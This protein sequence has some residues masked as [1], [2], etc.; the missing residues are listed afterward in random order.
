MRRANPTRKI[1]QLIVLCVFA[2]GTA[3]GQEFNDARTVEVFVGSGET[4]TESGGAVTLPVRLLNRSSGTQSVTYAVELPDGWSIATP[5]VPVTLRA[6]ESESRILLVR[7]PKGASA[8]RYTVHV[9]T[10]G[11]GGRSFHRVRHE[12]HV[13]P[14]C[15]VAL[16]V[17]PDVEFVEAGGL[18][19]IDTKLRNEGNVSLQA[20][21][22]V[23][24]HAGHRIVIPAD[25]LS[26]SPTAS[27]KLSVRVHVD[28]HV[29]RKTRRSVVFTVKPIGCAESVSEISRTV[30][31]D[32]IPVARDFQDVNAWIPASVTLSTGGGSSGI[33]G[34]VD[35][36]ASG[37]VDRDEKRQIDLHVRL[38]EDRTTR[39][40]RRSLVKARYL[41]NKVAVTVGDFRAGYGLLSSPSGVGRGVS[42]DA[43]HNSLRGGVFWSRPH[44]RFPV[45]ARSGVMLGLARGEQASIGAL[46]SRQTGVDRR[47]S[48]T[49][50]ARIAPI[51]DTDLLLEFGDSFR[52]TSGASA[53]AIQLIGSRR[54]FLTYSG[55]YIYAGPRFPGQ[56]ANYDFTQGSVSF[57]PVSGLHVSSGGRIERRTFESVGDGVTSQKTNELYDLGV[58]W[59]IRASQSEVTTAA[60]V[61]YS[62]R[63]LSGLSAEAADQR[64]AGLE[65]RLVRRHFAV[66][67][68]LQRGVYEDRVLQTTDTF[69]RTTLSARAGNSSRKAGVAFDWSSGRMITRPLAGSTVG[70]RVNLESRVTERLRLEMNAYVSRDGF[71]NEGVYGLVDLRAVRT[72]RNGGQFS[73]RAVHSSVGQSSA[74]STDLGISLRWP[75]AVPNLLGARSPRFEVEIV[76]FE[77][78]KPLSGVLVQLGDQH[79]LT[80]SNGRIT[81]RRPDAGVHLLRLDM[82]TVGVDYVPMAEMPLALDF[83]DTVESVE[84]PV[85]R[86][87]S[88]TIEAGM[89]SRRASLVAEGQDSGPAPVVPLRSAVIEIEDAFGR[90]RAV[91][92]VAGKTTFLHVRPGDYTV[93]IVY[94]SLP[95]HYQTPSGI[96]FHVEP[97]GDARIPLTAV[98]TRRQIQ[99]ITVRDDD[100]EEPDEAV[101][102]PPA[103]ASCEPIKTELTLHIVRNGESLSSIAGRYYGEPLMWPLIW[104]ANRSITDDPDLI[105][106]GHELEIET[107]GPSL[108]PV[109]YGRQTE[110]TTTTGDSLPEIS[111]RFTGDSRLWPMI[112]WANRSGIANPE[113]LPANLTLRWPV[114]RLI[115]LATSS[116]DE[117]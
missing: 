56:F 47:E 18:L 54:G 10:S 50:M 79:A 22:S 76:E 45:R 67:A 84:V 65:L 69:T 3:S 20:V 15:S 111:T 77:S 107:P 98:P 110:Y 116:C 55:R 72:L 52:G 117:D 115:P 89:L 73:V 97:G 93:R 26:V 34:H 28:E 42:I 44:F 105:H 46:F 100:S 90:Y 94:A 75:F 12:I 11:K 80:D 24:P 43:R 39:F 6:N 61:A 2:Y 102:P 71:W 108:D 51:R 87:S 5:P 112:W 81:L 82:S 60:T 14:H 8:G 101:L 106:A 38:P 35:V 63:S 99:M 27:R 86:A 114:M 92:N 7:V 85:A 33:G 96:S 29:R 48:V 95:P 103:V 66:G 74:G 49:L 58:G 113:Q 104:L 19:T 40:G 30:S 83:D 25:T 109:D 9:S 13:L 32:V 36:A 31:F 16:D 23:R 59:R 88:V 21:L 57:R 53:A 41:T 17:L 78:G 91:T 68:S 37:Y 62:K 1:T 4:S 70:G 64:H